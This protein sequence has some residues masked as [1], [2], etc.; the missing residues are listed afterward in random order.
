MSGVNEIKQLSDLGR[1]MGLTG[2]DL[3]GFVT[4]RLAA[5]EL[6]RERD[7]REK[8]REQEEREK[9][10][11]QE[12][13]EKLRE[14]EERERERAFQL[15]KMRL[16]KDIK[17]AEINAHAQAKEE[18]PPGTD[19]NLGLKFDLGKFDPGRENF[20][21]YLGK[22]EMIVETQKVPYEM[23]AMLLLS[24]LTGKALE[25]VNRL[26]PADRNDFD[27]L[28]LE[29]FEHFQLT[30]EGYR[31]KFRG[32]RPEKQESPRQFA[33][34]L[35][36]YLQR[37]IAMSGIEETY[38][39]L[40]DLM[41]REQFIRN[42]P[43]G[44]EV[45]IK[46]GQ[47]ESLD[48]VIERAAVYVGAHGPHSFSQSPRLR[49]FKPAITG[50][51][52]QRM[53]T[54]NQAVVNKG[55]G[56]GMESRKASTGVKP[57]EKGSY[58]SSGYNGCYTC[59]SQSH[60]K[61]Y[62]PLRQK[63]Y[64]AQGMMTM[65]DVNLAQS[66]HVGDVDVDRSVRSESERNSGGPLRSKD[67]PGK[68][69]SVHMGQAGIH[70]PQSSL[71][72]VD[73]S[74][75]VQPSENGIGKLGMA[76]DH[77][78]AM[79]K[80]MPVVSGRL[81]KGNKAVSVL[82][83]T[84]CS[85]C[86]VKAG[87]VDDSQFTG[88][89]QSVMLID[90][91]VKQFPV[92]KVVVDSP[93]YVGEIEA[94]CMPNSLCDVVIGNISGARE[95]NDP[96]LK[97]IPSSKADDVIEQV[98]E[99]SIEEG[100]QGFVVQSDEIVE[101]SVVMGVETRSQRAAREKPAKGLKVSDPVD[102]IKPADFAK[103]QREDP[104]LKPLWRKVNK[105]EKSKYRFIC[106]GNY[107][108]RQRRDVDNPKLG[109]G[110]R[111][112]VLP[113]S[114]RE[115]VMRIAHES[116]MGGHIGINNTM[117]KIKTQFFWPGMAED[118]ANFCRS[119]D[120]CQR[121]VSKG[122][123]PKA[124]LGRM[125]IIGVPF[126]RIAIDLAGPFTRSSRGHTH[127]LTIVD[128]ATR[129]VEAIPLKSITTID[130]A[131]ALL[132]VYSRVGIPKEV[133]SDLG[134]QFVSS[135]MKEVS[136]L[137]SIRQ[138]TSSRY[139][140]ICNGLVE[141]YNG[142]VKT[143]LRRLCSDEPREWDRYLPALLF[144]L[145]EIPS[146]SL[147]YSPFELLYGRNV[148]GPMDVLKELW[149]KEDVSSELK[150][151][152]EYV[153]QLRERLVKSWELAQETLKGASGR[154]K[155]YYDRSARKRK[156]S[157][158]D[159]VLIL[160]PTEQNKLMLQWKGPYPVVGTKYDYDYVVDV[161]GVSKTYH[162]N[163]LKRYFPR[164]ES[165]VTMAGCFDV[166]EDVDEVEVSE[167]RDVDG[168]GDVPVMPSLNQK[169]FAED[170]KMNEFLDE[171]QKKEL[172]QLLCEFQDVFTDVPK[173]TTASECKIF[174]TSEDPIRTPPYKVPQALKETLDQEVDNMLRLG[175]IEQADSPYGHPVV[176]V[177][178]P[179]GSNRFC[180]DFR[181][182]NNVTVFNP[183]PMPDPKDLFA[184]LGTSKFFSKLD[185]TKGYW[186]IPMRESD[187]DKTAFL[188]P[189][190]QYR[191]KYMP[192]GLVTAG[193]QFTKMMRG[194]LRGIPNV[195][196]Y[197]D[198]VLIHTATWA[199]HVETLRKVLQ[200]LREVN[201]AARPTKCA[202]GY[203][204]IEFLG[205]N[206]SEGTVQTSSRLIKKIVEAPRPQT[207]K[208]VRSFLGL[209]GYYREYIPNYATIALPL[210]ELTKK[211]KSNQLEW[212]ERE[213]DAFT[214]LKG[215]L[216]APPIL[217]LPCFD[218]L[219]KLKVDA[220]DKGIGAA[221]M[222][223]HAGND[224]PVAYA[225][226]KLLPREQN[227]STIEKECLAIIW[228]VKKFDYYLYG[229]QFE[230]HTDHKPLVYIQGK[231]FENKRIMRWSMILQDYRFRLVSVRGQDNTVAD[232]LSRT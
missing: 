214:E 52:K 129:Y 16:E 147:G 140:P 40:V 133:M 35:I 14:Q 207:K 25:V 57:H 169:E 199:E 221:L 123:V 218:K 134:P 125:P 131:E 86:V 112:V 20:D 50:P 181:R 130:V 58:T 30:E 105:D 78:G 232:Y 177:K 149:T 195:V 26:K 9:L 103:E 202:L 193:A 75:L 114:Q 98:D 204:T 102:S 48:E 161:A 188:T 216:A 85:T 226:K 41:L 230:I 99:S 175:I 186:Q 82:R 4:A 43:K 113:R 208:Q 220:S 91:S 167:E 209:T 110:P 212:G 150:D 138:L 201:L 18:K 179:D 142:L 69:D 63:P 10:R 79:M 211:G 198:D 189:S 215:C 196:H 141:R 44:V 127:I 225:S 17:L 7:E 182:L 205:H 3:N 203:K 119:C 87:L 36:G 145:R 47:C 183:E 68:V 164:E 77:V 223:E 172:S 32:A 88:S 51:S 184:T 132:S 6:E 170:V 100:P 124:T 148:R 56:K 200:R 117:A 11:E 194:V 34:R 120:I 187:K 219:F 118:I 122:R 27:K 146:S 61:K 178:K 81:V 62:C 222:Q 53:N 108:F 213:N 139:H 13:R 154:Y 33:G 84:G 165:Q 159:Q 24:N 29:L 71:E 191:F 151:E 46:E 156:L 39:G 74:S 136:R 67:S 180:I 160:L 176:M 155:E 152:Y 37:W 15:E 97:W 111:Y 229:R 109:V 116:L 158:G 92:A 162:I 121:T 59:G 106:E 224:F 96:D 190:G 93:F 5:I 197:I 65:D 228:A 89:K 217:R 173:K 8:L 76:Y 143:A 95:P 174:L 1:E 101:D 231:K 80:H 128:Y 60:I 185:M 38:E 55:P 157:V 192:F 12:E 126:E 107:L 104:T 28:K 21:D 72:D 73:I 144:A 227:Y 206:F 31:K 2:A 64:S 66:K 49:V 163:L 42:C 94:L 45:F 23:R 70:L 135:L 22:F 166:C 90:G 19:F 210:T 115:K 168:M 171:S 153:I 83:D 137:L 54:K